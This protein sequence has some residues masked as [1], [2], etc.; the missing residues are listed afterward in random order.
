MSRSKNIKTTSHRIIG[1]RIKHTS[2]RF[3]VRAHE[4]YEVSTLKEV[5]EGCSMYT[6]VQASGGLYVY[7]YVMTVQY[8]ETIKGTITCDR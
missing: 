6:C 3:T 8:V 1:Y 4:N 2:N 7:M 5:N